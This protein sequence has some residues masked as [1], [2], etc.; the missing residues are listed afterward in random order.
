MWLTCRARWLAVLCLVGSLQQA[1]QWHKSG[2]SQ[3]PESIVWQPLSISPQ[4]W[5]IFGTG[6]RQA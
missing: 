3:Q 1:P 5:P 2:P 4:I 6:N